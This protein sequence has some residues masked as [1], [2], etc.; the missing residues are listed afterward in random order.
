[1]SRR[2]GSRMSE[3]ESDGK[4][5][6]ARRSRILLYAIVSAA[7]VI[8][9]AW[10]AT[11]TAP[12]SGPPTVGLANV[13][14]LEVDPGGANAVVFPFELAPDSQSDDDSALTVTSASA[15]ITL[16]LPACDAANSSGCPG[17]V[18]EIL[19]TDQVTQF[20]TETNLT[21]IWCTNDSAGACVATVGGSYSLDLT[22]F[23]GDPLD[24]VVW[25]ASG[26]QWTDLSA[27]GTWTS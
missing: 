16:T 14:N 18:V 4:S 9:V 25:S 10:V 17:V 23:A 21:P 12:N 11:I 19:S 13:T 27:Q 26:V 24:L 2:N 15:T 20:P 7:I 22:P 5:R 1:M 6:M 3:S 8:T